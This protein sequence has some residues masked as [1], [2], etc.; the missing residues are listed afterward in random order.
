MPNTVGQCGPLLHFATRPKHEGQSSRKSCAMHTRPCFVPRYQPKISGRTASFSTIDD[1]RTP[2]GGTGGPRPT[3]HDEYSCTSQD[4]SEFDI[5]STRMFSGTRIAT[6]VTGNSTR[7]DSTVL[8]SNMRD[9][10]STTTANIKTS[11]GPPYSAC[12]FS[13]WGSLPA[14]ACRAASAP[15]RPPT[16]PLPPRERCR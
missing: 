4:R 1:R 14:L 7:F 5:F 10:T 8:Y 11:A 13:T 12:G 3:S 6:C 9:L 15:H 16:P 2:C